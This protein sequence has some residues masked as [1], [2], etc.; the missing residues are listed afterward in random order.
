[1][2][3]L[4]VETKNALAG[5][6]ARFFVGWCVAVVMVM[7]TFLVC[8]KLYWIPAFAGMTRW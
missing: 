2:I 1:L 8:Q 3:G 5:R 6:L 4:V 7:V